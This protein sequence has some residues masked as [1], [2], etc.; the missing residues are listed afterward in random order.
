M[1]VITRYIK[2]HKLIQF[3][4]DI[5]TY[6]AYRTLQVFL[7]PSCSLEDV[8]AE[9]HVSLFL[10]RTTLGGARIRTRTGSP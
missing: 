2:G 4:D 10:I 8:A 1:V 5:D 6:T 9:V 3:T 7:A